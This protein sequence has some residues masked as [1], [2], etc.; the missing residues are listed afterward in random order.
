[1]R[2][3][4]VT[5][6][7]AE[8]FVP[9]S[10]RL[11]LLM[12]DDLDLA[13][14]SRRARP[15]LLFFGKTVAIYGVWY[16]LYDPWLLPDGQLDEWVSHSVVQVGAFRLDLVGFDVAAKARTFTL[17]GTS[18]VR[19]V[20]G[21]NGIGSI[22]LFAGFAVAFPGRAWHRARFVPLGVLVI[23]LSNVGRV[24]GLLLLQNYWDV[25]FSAAHSVGALMFFY[26]VVFGLW[27]L[28]V[29]CG[30]HATTNIPTSASNEQTHPALA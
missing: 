27:V 29:N 12:L 9:V 24:T 3:H 20:D 21:C 18:G 1:M 22:G 16:V 8:A 4:A 10:D 13:A 28:W 23:Y 7:S 19:V 17:P 26:A 11:F 5:R 6:R 14:R 25:G 30:G 2:L 15:L